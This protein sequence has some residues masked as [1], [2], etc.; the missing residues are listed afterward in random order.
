[1]T[2]LGLGFG[3]L[4]QQGIGS[5]MNAYRA[6]QQLAMARIA[7]QAAMEQDALR[8]EMMRE[9]L[10]RRRRD[11][12]Q[13]LVQ[14]EAD[15][16]V[17]NAMSTAQAPTVNPDGTV[18]DP[19]WSAGI[20]ARVMSAASP[21]IQ[22]MLVQHKTDRLA[23]PKKRAELTN[24]YNAAKAAGALQ[25]IAPDRWDQYIR[26]GVP[27]LDIEKAPES[28][29]ERGIN[30]R[31]NGKQAMV[32]LM[33]I[34]ETDGSMGPPAVNEGQRAWLSSLP[35]EAVELM[36]RQQWLPAE[37]QRREQKQIESQRAMLADAYGAY[38]NPNASPEQ[39]ATAQ[40]ILAQTNSPMPVARQADPLAASRV[41][42]SIEQAK[43]DLQRAED[44]YR[45]FNADAK[46][47]DGRMAPPTD[48]EMKAA[49]TTGD[50]IDT[51]LMDLTGKNDYGEKEVASAKAKVS[52]W[53][54]LQDSAKR[55]SET[56]KAAILSGDAPDSSPEA[57]QGRE[58]DEAYS[59]GSQ[60][61]PQASDKE[62]MLIDALIDEAIGGGE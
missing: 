43:S 8:M 15:R 45:S 19:D 13:F 1:M 22:E 4:M 31:E 24:E 12:E 36:F 41:R 59:G 18:T 46:N 39:R 48:D 57:V 53:K 23:I 35:A 38:N 44:E 5:G 29:R 30:L 40:A 25:L 32:D 58:S 3:Q 34:P 26:M 62:T 54:K 42:W 14:Q 55:L 33:T 21:R 2:Q 16:N 49:E 6:D 56:Y 37:K 50:D 51:G 28:I 7:Q 20:D 27:G 61:Q 9:D 11:A 10:A 47:A 17:F 52:A 60:I